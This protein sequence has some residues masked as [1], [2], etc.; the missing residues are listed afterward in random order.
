[1]KQTGVHVHL[2]NT[3]VNG[4]LDF[5]LGGA[6]AAMEDEEAGKTSRSGKNERCI[7]TVILTAVVR[8]FRRS[9]SWHTTGVWKEVQGAIVR[10]PVCIRRARFR[11]QPLC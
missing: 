4:S 1:M 6:R 10:Y 8:S 9:G 3:I 11:T 7:L 5:L 2:D